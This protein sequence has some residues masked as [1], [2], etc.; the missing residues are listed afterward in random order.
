MIHKSG[1]ERPR[2]I[3]E[4]WAAR[5]R[6]INVRRKFIPNSQRRT[7]TDWKGFKGFVPCE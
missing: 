3:N 6:G 5:E 4:I 7:D 1:R 2:R